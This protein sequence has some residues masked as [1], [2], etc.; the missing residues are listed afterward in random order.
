MYVV[1]DLLLLLL[2]AL[3]YLPLRRLLRRR[4]VNQADTRPLLDAARLA[5]AVAATSGKSAVNLLLGRLDKDR[6]LESNLKTFA[7]AYLFHGAYLLI[8]RRRFDRDWDPLQR[9][10]HEAMAAAGRRSAAREMFAE[11]VD[12]DPAL[13][14][15]FYRWAFGEI[16]ATLPRA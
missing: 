3:P 8:G 11:W 7:L 4:Y 15:R 14:D 1:S 12:E 5:R 16:I 9:K 6:N 13:R 2:D 10:A